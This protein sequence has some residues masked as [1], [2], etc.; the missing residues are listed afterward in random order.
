M[1]VGRRAP[2]DIIVDDASLSRLHAKFVW[3]DDGVWLED[4]GSTNG[5]TANDKKVSK[6]LLV[7]GDTVKLGAVPVRVHALHAPAPAEPILQNDEFED[8]LRARVEAQ[9]AQPVVLA[10]AMDGQR[11]PIDAW[12]AAL[13]TALLGE[14]DLGFYTAG[15]LAIAGVD[16]ADLEARLAIAVRRDD[17]RIGLASYPA[18]A[19]SVDELFARVHR[20]LDLTT[21]GEPLLTPQ[22]YPHEQSATHVVASASMRGVY[23]QVDRVAA[24]RAPVLLVGETGV[25]KELVAREIHERSD[26]RGGPM[27][28]L[29]CGAI[30]STL[31]ESL[32]FGHE[33]GAFT[34]A[35]KRMPGIF[36]QAEG[37]TVFLDEIGELPAETQAA[38]LRTLETGRV[39]R[40]GSTEEIVVD[41]RIISATHRDLEGMTQE[42]RFRQDLLYRLNTV[43]I[44]VPP[45]RERAEEIRPLV[46]LFLRKAASSGGRGTRFSERALAAFEKY[47]W[48]GNVRELRNVVDRAVIM[49]LRD[50]IDIGELPAPI[51]HGPGPADSV[52]QPTGQGTLRDQL[53][54]FESQL[55]L[56]AL[57]QCGNNKTRAAEYLGIPVRTL[58]HKIQA[59]GLKAKLA[60]SKG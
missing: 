47:R 25:G 3:E 23:A 15:G 24:T 39:V 37:G 32:L 7:P 1:V 49:A 14:E 55:I 56:D 19:D 57:A 41:V 26:R 6:A 29:N 45:L 58:S 51:V 40:L 50:E 31:Q 52:R 48:P 35:D 30:P 22:H 27:K 33:R 46:A 17:L 36:E 13:R 38:L 44:G 21:A 11:Q 9:P 43:M 12:V 16:R 18:D 42:G 5:S 10:L 54:A 60:T 20:L 34:G 28:A 59:L 53:K 8:R 2:A 4:L